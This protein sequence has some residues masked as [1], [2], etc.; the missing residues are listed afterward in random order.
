ME[1]GSTGPEIDRERRLAEIQEK[2]RNS[3]ELFE[4]TLNAMTAEFKNQPPITK[5]PDGKLSADYHGI[6][7]LQ[8]NAE[9]LTRLSDQMSRLYAEQ[10]DLAN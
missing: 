1:R 7:G 9:R 6:T 10:S 5:R 8:E 4:L 3:K 2:L